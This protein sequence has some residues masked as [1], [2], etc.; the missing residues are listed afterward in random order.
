MWP[1][2]SLDSH[3]D[4]FSSRRCYRQERATKQEQKQTAES[5]ATMGFYKLFSRLKCFF[6][7]ND[8]IWWYFVPAN[9]LTDWLTSD[10]CISLSDTGRMQSDR[11]VR[12]AF[13][14]LCLDSAPL[15]HSST[16][17]LVALLCLVENI[18]FFFFSRFLSVSQTKRWF[19]LSN[20]SFSSCNRNSLSCSPSWD[21]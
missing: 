11:N 15:C 6:E 20:S 8:A 14:D 12:D 13:T 7:L 21:A 16:G 9:K 10:R 1:R 4:L 19:M 5:K 3:F 17:L 18:F 2:W